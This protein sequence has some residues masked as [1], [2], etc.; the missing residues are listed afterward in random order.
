MHNGAEL[1]GAG[2]FLQLVFSA[3]S[4]VRFSDL[5]ASSLSIRDHEIVPGL[6]NSREA[7]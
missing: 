3:E 2:L 1:S 6:D 7:P 4:G 5:L